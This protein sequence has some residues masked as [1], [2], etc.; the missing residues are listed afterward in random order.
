MNPSTHTEKPQVGSNEAGHSKNRDGVA[1]RVRKR[2]ADV[3][4]RASIEGRDAIHKA[5]ERLT[6][7]FLDVE[8]M[9]DALKGLEG[10]K[11]EIPADEIAR[12]ASFFPKELTPDTLAQIRRLKNVTE[13]R[14]S[15]LVMQ[16]PA[17]ILVDGKEMPFCIATMEAV[18]DKAVMG[19]K[20]VKP[21]Y[22]QSEFITEDTVNSVPDGCL[23]VWTSACLSG[24][25]ALNYGRQLGVQSEILGQEQRD[26]ENLLRRVFHKSSTDEY[27]IYPDM[28]LAMA[29]HYIARK[30][31]L[32]R[33]DSMGLN[34]RDKEGD[35][36]YVTF[37]QSSL[38]L[39]ISDGRPWAESGIGA[40][41]SIPSSVDEL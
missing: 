11:V 19:G 41:F 30:E 4:D 3:T 37:D 7:R 26:G 40:S 35:P 22:Y 20:G 5:L 10:V 16:L 29:L 1:K 24:S 14:K 25:K 12:L 18:M 17:K 33:E 13:G 23:A 38:K 6:S 28:L 2:V 32:I 15:P 27:G 34:A 31:E 21:I 8:A 39:G 36:L 9:N